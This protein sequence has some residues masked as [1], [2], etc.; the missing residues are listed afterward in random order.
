MEGSHLLR[1]LLLLKPKRKQTNA[2][3]NK[4]WWGE[5]TETNNKKNETEDEDIINI[6][7]FKVKYQ[8]EDEDIIE[9][10]KLLLRDRRKKNETFMDGERT[11]MVV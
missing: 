1:N 11:I 5:L 6:K 3:K 10:D 8:K 7:F 4:D 9:R 2:T